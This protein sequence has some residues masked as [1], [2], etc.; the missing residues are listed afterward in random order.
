MSWC[1][2]REERRCFH[3]PC[4]EIAETWTQGLV[5]RLASFAQRWPVWEP[6]WH[7][8]N[9]RLGRRSCE[10][11]ANRSQQTRGHGAEV[12]SGAVPTNFLC[13]P[14]FVLNQ[15]S[16]PLLFFSPPNLQTCLRAWIQ[17]HACTRRTRHQAS[18]NVRNAWPKCPLYGSSEKCPV[19]YLHCA[20]FPSVAHFLTLCVSILANSAAASL[21]C[22]CA[23]AVSL[24][25]CLKSKQSCLVWS[26]EQLCGSLQEGKCAF[27]CRKHAL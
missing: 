4:Y 14:N 8:N 5:F 9:C 24:S 3:F 6:L 21:Y 10:S 15:K 19:P 20:L 26:C 16:R 1:W 17:D 27:L 25:Y 7:Q 2:N 22:Y 18:R 23:C 12:H 13:S 11:I